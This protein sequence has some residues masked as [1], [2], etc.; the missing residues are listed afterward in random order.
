MDPE[1]EK[2]M[3]DLQAGQNSDQF[4]CGWKWLEWLPFKMLE[5]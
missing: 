5:G 2:R 1:L 3:V 4:V